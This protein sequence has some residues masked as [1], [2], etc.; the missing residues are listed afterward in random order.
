MFYIFHGENEFD[1]DEA[2]ARLRRSLTAGHPGS[3][4]R[5]DPAMVELNTT[6]FDG[7]RLTLG[8]L[9]HVCDAIPFM[10]G[11]RLV[12]V[13]GL[14]T[15]LASGRKA[16]EQDSA[17][18]Q[19]PTW[20]RTFRDELVKY[21]PNL[22]PT[23]RLIFVEPKTLSTSDPVLKLAQEQKK[24]EEGQ[25]KEG[26]DQGFEMAFHLPK[27]KDLVVWIQNRVRDGNG[28]I[29]GDAAAMLAMLIGRDLRSLDHE[30][31]K[32]LTYT[33]GERP[34]SAEDVRTLVSRARETSVF[35]L[36]DCV[37][38][39]ETARALQ[40][41]HY[42]LEQGEHPLQVL[43]M[44]ARQVRILI[45]VSELRR[46]GLVS[47]EIAGQLAVAPWM[48]DKFLDQAQKF[49]MAQLEAAHRRLVETDWAIKTGQMEETLALD[50][51]VVGLGQ[52]PARRS[53]A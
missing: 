28:R 31:D 8:E 44:L 20:K 9:R 6:V 50:L 34:V 22:P 42:L 40:W 35:D 23:T 3:P 13:H 45:Q 33:G 7:S 43:T 48:A 51:L 29:S 17:A 10:A 53:Q 37:G 16:E 52:R 4:G 11:C 2:L 25:G 15:R 18:D 24:A 39:R 30:I 46:Q 21:L 49:D 14:L 1:R 38:R 12:I 32:L 41:L 36:V 47:Q 19:D 27:E 5:D 26:K